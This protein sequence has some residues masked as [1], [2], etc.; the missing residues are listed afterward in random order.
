MIAYAAQSGA[1]VPAGY[2]GPRR[3]VCQAVHEV[4]AE[5]V[6]TGSQHYRQERVPDRRRMIAPQLMAPIP[7]RARPTMVSAFPVAMDA[8]APPPPVPG[9]SSGLTRSR[10]RAELPPEQ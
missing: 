7:S 2:R 1:A 10:A 4:S 6:G 5:D 9:P 3:S 8:P